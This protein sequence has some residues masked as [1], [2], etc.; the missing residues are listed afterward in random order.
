MRPNQ[1]GQESIIVTDFCNVSERAILLGLNDPEGLAF[2]PRNFEHASTF[3]DLLHEG[4]VDTLRKLFRE[5]DLHESRVEQDG[6]SIPLIVEKSFDLICPTLF[7]GGVILSESPYMFS[8]ALEIITGYAI[9]YFKGIVGDRKVK[10]NL[11]YSLE[12]SN[13]TKVY[14]KAE[15]EGPVEGLPEIGRAVRKMLKE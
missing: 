11:V 2:L 4:I 9:E 6:Q 15:Y 12:N 1:Q 14:K 7:V 13:G 5:S 8:L 10:F 3:D